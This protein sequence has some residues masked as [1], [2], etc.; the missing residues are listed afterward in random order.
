MTALAVARIPLEGETVLSAVAAEV[1]KK[2]VP[3]HMRSFSDIFDRLSRAVAV[4]VA[5]N[6]NFAKAKNLPTGT[7]SARALGS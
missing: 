3:V 7:V 4:P 5:A 2:R 1:A 6:D